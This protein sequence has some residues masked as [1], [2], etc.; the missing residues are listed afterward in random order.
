M[1]ETAKPRHNRACAHNPAAFRIPT[2]DV[3]DSSDGESL[4]EFVRSSAEK[5][6][7]SVCTRE[8][9]RGMRRCPDTA[10]HQKAHS[11]RD[12]PTATCGHA[13]RIFRVRMWR[14]QADSR[15]HIQS[16]RYPD[17]SPYR[18]GNPGAACCAESDVQAQLTDRGM[19]VS[20][21]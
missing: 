1:Q 14:G 5:P 6:Q 3:V 21:L 12:P 7:P 11:S 13:R 8:P 20:S 4:W 17:R 10:A 18:C 19:N 9:G 15:T 16:Y 2:L